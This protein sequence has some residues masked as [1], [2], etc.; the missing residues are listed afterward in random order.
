MMSYIITKLRYYIAPI[1]NTCCVFLLSRSS[2]EEL[3]TP[4]A[5]EEKVSTS[6]LDLAC[7][8]FTPFFHIWQWPSLYVCLSPLQQK[9]LEIERVEKWLK[10]VKKWDKYRNS[11]KVC[12]SVAVDTTTCGF[13]LALSSL[14]FPSQLFDELFPLL[15]IICFPFSF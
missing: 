1:S 4:S 15:L 12:N 13:N 11:E 8:M 9:H 3:P 5:L 10:M 7:D 6:D 14:F 2:E